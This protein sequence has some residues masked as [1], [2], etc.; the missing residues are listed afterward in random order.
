MHIDK[1][2]DVAVLVV[3]ER[4]EALVDDLVHLDGLCDHLGRVH[5]AL[6]DDIDDLLKV[7]VAESSTVES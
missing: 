1:D 3:D 5:L 2:L 7:A 6:G 4:H